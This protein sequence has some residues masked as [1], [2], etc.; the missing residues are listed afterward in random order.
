MT[1]QAKYKL[2]K[3]VDRNVSHRMGNKGLETY[4]LIVHCLTLQEEEFESVG[5]ADHFRSL[6]DYPEDYLIIQTW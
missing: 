1:I 2:L 5:E 4:D 6:K 3:T